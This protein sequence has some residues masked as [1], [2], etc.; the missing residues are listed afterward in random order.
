ME[1]PIRE[2]S[3]SGRSGFHEPFEIGPTWNLYVAFCAIAA[4]P[5]FTVLTQSWGK[6]ITFVSTYQ[7]LLFPLLAL[8]YLRSRV[9]RLD[10]ERIIQ[11]FP[12]LGTSMQY[13]DIES[14]HSKICSGKGASTPVLVICKRDSGRRIVIYIRSVDDTALRQFVRLL[15]EKAPQL[16]VDGLILTAF[17]TPLER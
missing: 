11:G 15:K 9:V 6:K 2:N 16:F 17:A 7:Y 12:I 14:I 13:E 5:E 3:L 4:L 1:H 10:G 8:L